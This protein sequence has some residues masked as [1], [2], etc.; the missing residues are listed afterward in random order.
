MELFENN[1]EHLGDFI[2]LNEEWV[3]HYFEI[4]EA[5][6]NLAA[7]PAGVI[8]RGW[9]I[10]SLVVDGDVVGVCALFNEGEGQ[11]ELARM[12]VCPKHQGKGYGGVLIKTVLSKL[13][14]IGARKVFLSSNTKL[15]AA[16][17]LY[18]KHGFETVSTGQHPSYNRCN[19]VMEKEMG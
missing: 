6:R 3:A 17:S 15:E 9:Y 12:A 14:A 11:Y 7:D 5:D 13:C 1:I 2:R 4:E 16:I 8:E 18:R 10:F 19:I